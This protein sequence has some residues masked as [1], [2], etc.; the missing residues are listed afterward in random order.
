MLFAVLKMEKCSVSDVVSEALYI[1][2]ELLLFFLGRIAIFGISKLLVPWF[3]SSV[4]TSTVDVAA[5][6]VRCDSMKFGNRLAT[7]MKVSLHSIS[8][9]ARKKIRRSRSGS[10]YAWVMERNV[11]SMLFFSCILA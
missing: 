4:I 1:V 8:L 10:N 7:A 11:C 5:V 3:W 6:S 9:G 2:L